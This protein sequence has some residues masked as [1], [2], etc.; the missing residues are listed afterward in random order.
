MIN[1]T[2]KECNHI[3][4]I[5]NE[6]C[7]YNKQQQKQQTVDTVTHARTRRIEALYYMHL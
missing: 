6:S 1:R 3:D 2:E 5:S 4:V 7:R